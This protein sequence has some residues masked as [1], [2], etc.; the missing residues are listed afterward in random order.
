MEEQKLERA[1]EAVSI[2]SLKGRQGGP[3]SGPNASV[4]AMSVR[5]VEKKEVVKDNSHSIEYGIPSVEEVKKVD[6]RARFAEIDARMLEESKSNVVSSRSRRAEED[7]N[8]PV[9]EEEE[10]VD[11][12]VVEEKHAEKAEEK[13]KGV[14]MKSPEI[15]LS[16]PLNH[17]LADLGASIN[18]M[19]YSIYKQLDLGEPQPTRMS[20]SLADRLVKYPR[21][22]VEN[23]L[24]KVGKFFFPMDFIILQMEVDDKIPLI[25]GCPFLR[26][27][28]VMIDVFDGK[29]TLR[30]GD[31]SIT[32]DAMKSVKDVGEHSHSVCMLD[33]FIGEFRDSNLVEDVIDGDGG[34]M[35]DDLPDW[36]AEFER[37]LIWFA[38]L[39]ADIDNCKDH[40]DPAE[41]LKATPLVMSHIKPL[42]CTY[43]H[44]EGI[45]ADSSPKSRPPLKNRYPLPRIDDLFDQLQ[46]ARYFSKIDLRSGYH[47]LKLQEEDVPKTTFRTRYGHYELLVMSFGLTNAP[48]ASMDLINRVCKPFLDKFVI[49]FID[50]ILIYSQSKEEHAKHLRI[51]LETLRKERLYASFPNVNFGKKRSTIS[52]ARYKRRKSIQHSQK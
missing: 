50:D 19:P 16:L 52:W 8:P 22:I 41:R 45:E 37:N 10:P 26:T 29:L 2:Q 30:V 7:E 5:S 15:D 27:T 47:Q 48:A 24:V 1:R 31:E 38:F 18:L 13:K 9:V 34:G 12:R 36:L 49:V 11:E 23:L 21:G 28:K 44:A 39:G 17:A 42:T 6:W 3:S 20:I 32:F 40:N 35:I 4:M 33:A 51:I 14:E 46:G 43:M 25:L